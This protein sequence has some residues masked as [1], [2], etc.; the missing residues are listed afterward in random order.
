MPSAET[1]ATRTTTKKSTVAAPASKPKVKT[2]DPLHCDKF[3][4]DYVRI[5]IEYA[6]E[7]ADEANKKKFGRWIRL[8]AQRFLRDLDRAFS[9][10]PPFTF[11]AWSACDP[12]DFI[13]KLPHIQGKWYDAKGKYTR[14]IILHP[15]DV[16]FIVNLFGFRDLDGFR[17]FTMALKAVARKNAKSTI[18]AGIGLYC[19]T[20]EGEV[21]PH[22]ISAATTGSQARIVFNIAKRMAELTTDLQEA[23]FLK[24]YANS[25]ACFKNGGFF[26]PI[27]SK[28]STQDGLNPSASIIDEIHAHKNHDLLNVIQSAAGARANPLF[29]FTTTE[30]YESPG[31]WPELRHFAKQVL[32]GLFEADHFL[33]VYYAL[34]EEDE[35][36]GIKADEDFDEEAWIKANPLIE[37][38][39]LLLKEIRK[40]AIDAKHMPGK[41]AEFRI[42]RLNRPSATAKGFISYAHWQKC[43]GAVDLNWLE[44][45]PCYAG[46]DLASTRDLASCRLVWL[47]EGKLYTYGIRWTPERAVAT[48][49]ERGTV[50]YQGWVTRGLL[51][52][53]PGEVIDHDVVFNDIMELHERFNIQLLSYDQWN[54]SQVA[55][56]LKEAEVATR[57]F[58]QGT[59]SYHPAMKGFEELYISGNFV[60]D[61]DPVLLWCASNMVVRYDANLNM[62]PDRKRSYEKIDDFVA[63]LMGFGGMILEEE[64]DTEPTLHF[65][66]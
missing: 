54:A 20:C 42:K 2:K 11:D 22:V 23:F 27:N 8:A 61:G 19:E 32:L 64:T 17:R 47:V 59:K 36:A 55:K 1:V 62:A 26:K 58:I 5:A 44:Q 37:V 7:A 18:A 30:G 49:T 16:F 33:V 25:I 3:P 40:A 56:R 24:P 48:R 35:A 60:H 10:N 6:R 29:L 53:T 41:L 14:T 66:G 51:K 21:G 43:K 12:C 52:T 13:E 9:D 31:P 38:N 15:S 65:A 39:P 46:L 57:I 28:A 4:K 50:P 34:D 63:L 45:F